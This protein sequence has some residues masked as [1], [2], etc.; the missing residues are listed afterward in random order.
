M[1]FRIFTV[2]QNIKDLTADGKGKKKNLRK[3]WQTDE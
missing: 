3:P 1:D 2:I